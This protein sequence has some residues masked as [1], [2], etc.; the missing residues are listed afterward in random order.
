MTVTERD[1]EA[2][3]PLLGGA[4]QPVHMPVGEAAGVGGGDVDCL[5]WDLDPTWPV[6]APRG[7]RLVQTIRYDVLAWY[8]VLER[9]GDALAVDALADPGGIGQYRWPV[10]PDSLPL[11]AGERAGYLTAKRIRKG[12][13]DPGEWARIGALAAEDPDGFRSSLRAPFGAHAEA[14]ASEVLSGGLPAAG[15]DEA[16]RRQRAR[17]AASSVRLAVQKGGRA[18]GRWLAPT[19]FTVLLVGPD[20]TGKSSVAEAVRRE[21]APFF[22][23]T[24]SQHWR[25]GLLPRSGDVS[26]APQ[27][28]VTQ[29][30]S[31]GTRGTAAS[32]VAA[33]YHWGDFFLAGW[34]TGRARLVRSTLVVAERGWHDLAVDPRR[35]RLDVPPG[36]VR[37]AGRL[38]PRPDLV[39]VLDV[40]PSVAVARKPELPEEE[41]ARQAE[42]WRRDPPPARARV[43]I[44]ADRSLDEVVAGVRAAVLDGMNERALRRLGPGWAGLPRSSHPRW[45]IPRGPAPA[46]AA[47]LAVYHPVTPAGLAGW[48]VART[49]A[50]AGAL[51]V[52]PRGR[53]LP[54]EVRARLAPHV[55][56]HGSVALLRANHPGRYVALILTRDGS[57]AAVAKVALDAAGAAALFAEADALEGPA[58]SLPGPLLAPRVSH[59]S[60]GLLVTD[61]AVWRPRAR[62]WRLPPEVA[63]AL[64]EWF[65]ATGASHGDFAPW[66]LLRTRSG[67]TLV[68]WESGDPEGAPFEDVFHWFVQCHALLGRLDRSSLLRGLEGLGPFGTALAAYRAGARLAAAPLAER[69]RDYL[70]R[71][72]ARLPVDTP[73]GARGRNARDAL[74]RDLRL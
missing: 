46:A 65:A 15:W 11:T 33:A 29:P 16:R 14:L 27:R 44:D 67:W 5:V 36:L 3:V 18:L 58:R 20:G 68:D 57:P 7:W 45:W 21:C 4:A 40:T 52:W 55:P 54:E 17:S 38:L 2:L 66:N 56:P 9:D 41:V 73:D 34:T 35:Y 28:D 63:G 72:R 37:A 50:R 24:E 71:S 30:H 12:I 69:F 25:P 62:P 59:A 22:R 8:W 6:R 60:A 64:G 1:V 39:C 47:G 53:G 51:S 42:A 74:L 10:G 13:R 26:G 49:V 48:A 31:G 23:R 19:G 70:E 43:V 32:L 61:A